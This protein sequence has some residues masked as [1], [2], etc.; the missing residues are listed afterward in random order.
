M[1]RPGIDHVSAGHILAYDARTGEILWA[2]EKYV[3]IDPDRE[4]SRIPISATEQA[5]LRAD[6]AQVFRDREV[7]VLVVHGD[8]EL[9]ENTRI[10]VDTEE[11]TF[12]EMPAGPRNLTDIL[13][14]GASS[15]SS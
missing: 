11:V 13:S 3:E 5:Q 14:R 2:H 1:T 8:F 6:V 4:D 10:A 9:R 15:E 7:R 12:G